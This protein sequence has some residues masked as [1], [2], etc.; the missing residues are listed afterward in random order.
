M[1]IRLATYGVYF[2]ETGYGWLCTS[3]GIACLT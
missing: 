1:V 2:V 3:T